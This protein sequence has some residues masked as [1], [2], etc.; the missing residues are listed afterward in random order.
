MLKRGFKTWCESTSL[1]YRKELSLDKTDS[2]C[3][4]NLAKHLNI[5]LVNPNQM[6]LSKEL[7]K[8]LLQDEESS[9]SAV[10]ITKGEQYLIIYNSSHAPT[11][12]SND[13][14]HELSHIILRHKPYTHYSQESGVFI[15]HYDENQEDEADCLASILLLP[16]DVLIKIKFSKK[17]IPLAAREYKVSQNLLQM[18]LNTSG[19]NFIYK[20]SKG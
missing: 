12:Q 14:M 11:R 18:R 13:V 19:V 10:T 7:L 16:R 2:L 20:K 9:W 5:S 3:P 17:P 1:S 6:A 4:F 8:T 15:R